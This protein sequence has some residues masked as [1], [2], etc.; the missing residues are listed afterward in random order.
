MSVQKDAAGIQRRQE[1]MIDFA[2]I[3]CQ[4]ETPTD[5]IFLPF[6]E[7][8]K[9][10]NR[11]VCRSGDVVGI[12]LERG[13]ILKD[14]D[15]L[16]SE[17]GKVILVR[18][19][20]EPL[21]VVRTSKAIDLARAAYHLGNRHVLLQIRA[22]DVSYQKD[23]VLDQMITK[24]GF[25]VTHEHIPFEPE[26]GAYHSHPHSEGQELSGGHSHQL[27]QEAKNR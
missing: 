15:C 2:Q 25:S 6:E 20:S 22:D 16:R 3:C 7:R 26:S 17:T 21:S 8:R 5:E 1:S 23:H 4:P 27:E 24:L 12:V 9:S 19:A 18:A 11:V 10:R 14:G 13:T